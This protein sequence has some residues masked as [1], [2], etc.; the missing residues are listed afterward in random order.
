MTKSHML[1]GIAAITL[2][3]LPGA[4]LAQDAP[5]V[6]ALEARIAYLERE[7]D[8]LRADVTAAR[9]QQ[10]TQGQDI[11]RLDQ[12]V[13]AAPAPAPAPAP[14]DGFR[15]GNNTV[16][17]GGFVKADYSISQYSGG[18]PANGDAQR[19][20]YLPGTIPVGGA[21]EGEAT[22]FNARQTRFWLTTDGVIGGRKVGTRVE[23]D[24]QVLPGTGDQR[25]TSP[26]NPALR[27]AFVTIDNW[28]FGQEW[29]NFQILSVLPETADYV[30]PTEGTTFNRQVQ[31]RYTRGP[32]SI[33]LE[34]PETT[35]TPFGAASRIVA[36]DNTLPD[37]TMRYTFTRPWGEA[38]V[39]G[40]VRQLAYETTGV[41]AIESSTVG[42]GIS[43]AA[44]V[45]VGERDDLKFML[46]AGEGIG[47]YVGLNFAN[48]A[49]L[50]ASGELEAIPLVAGFAAYRHYWRP[51]WRS[52]L[53]YAFQNVD[54]DPALLALSTNAAAQSVRANL[55][56]SPVPSFDVGSELSF[57]ERELESGATGDVTRLTFF[58]KYGF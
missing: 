32:F 27:R 22:D 34:N 52:S 25:T 51:N 49:V 9:A 5:D 19:D 35:V 8:L 13:A 47:R 50:D 6:S 21:D 38:A 1:G 30:G 56:W 31:V 7:I 28:L 40:I 43:A 12:Q 10:A 57:G 3:G 20:F 45:K 24:F 26:S 46:T 14:A 33:A 29:T 48:D 37:L 44:R 54:N 55:I 15:I 4:V 17:Y 58:A 36:D 11:I 39:S 23:F 42:W 41:G 18:D 53:I 2:I 16:R